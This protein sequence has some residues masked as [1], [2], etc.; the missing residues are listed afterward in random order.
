MTSGRRLIGEAMRQRLPCSNG[1]VDSSFTAS[2]TDTNY[3]GR[4]HSI[5]VIKQ[6][7][8]NIQGRTFL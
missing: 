2:P 3:S 7:S 4:K 5:H 8:T 1:E 6:Q